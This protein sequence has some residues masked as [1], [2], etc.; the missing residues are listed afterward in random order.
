M[1]AQPKLYPGPYTA[2]L[3]VNTDL[4]DLYRLLKNGAYIHAQLDWWSLEDWIGYPAFTVA[5]CNDCIAGFSLAVCDASP[6]AWWRALALDKGHAP[7]ALIGALLEPTLQGLKQARASRLTCM[8]FSDW[9][10]D[11]LP[12]WGFGLVAQVITLRKDDR[13]VPALRNAVRVRS[14][15]QA[16]I[17]D[18][19]SV[20]Q[21]AF[22]PTWRYGLEGLARIWS[23]MRHKFVAEQNGQVIG[24]ACGET[25]RSSGYVMRLAVDP[26]H[27]GRTIGAALL[28]ASLRSF[29]AAGV[30]SITLNTQMDNAISQKLYGC[31]GFAPVGYPANVWQRAA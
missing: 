1:F 14:A 15:A 11:V 19:L 26:A 24:Y 29:F 2:R 27:Q 20:D 10:D 16:D 6:A 21:A 22:E 13:R 12:H 30:K 4:P 5:L 23:K 25:H 9:L 17:P 7:Q 3:A 8:A 31:F 28:A 18:V